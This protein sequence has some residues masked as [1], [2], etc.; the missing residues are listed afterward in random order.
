MLGLS[1]EQWID[2]SKMLV[3][4]SVT[5]LSLPPVENLQRHWK[6]QA[7]V[8]IGWHREKRDLEK[9]DPY[10]FDARCRACRSER[11]SPVALDTSG[12]GSDAKFVH[13]F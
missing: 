11:M 3:P 5:V 2:F 12:S 10:E 6:R 1:G 8:K 9:P 4:I 13:G 7:V